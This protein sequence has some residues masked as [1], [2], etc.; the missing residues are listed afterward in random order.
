MRCGMCEAGQV[1][2]KH[3]LDAGGQLRHSAMCLLAAG[4][5]D[6]RRVA[7]DAASAGRWRDLFDLC[8]T[9]KVLS[10]LEMRIVALGIVLR[11]A[12]RAELSRSTQPAFVQS[13]LCLRAGATALSVLHQAGIE[14][15]GFK[16]I[17]AL[18]YVYAGPRHRTLQDVDV[19]IHRRDVELS[20]EVLQRAGF[21][22]SPDVPWNEYVAFLR[23]SPG[24]AG[25][26][27]VSLR[28][29]RGGAVDLH[30]HLGALE[31]ETLLAGASM[32]DVLQR[33]LPLMSASHSMLLSVHHA[34]RNDFVP[35]DI[36]RDVCDFPHWQAL[37]AKRGEWDKLSEDAERWGLS[38]ACAALA[39]IVAGLRGEPDSEPPLPVSPEDQAA[40]KQLA[41]FYFHQL[42]TGAINTDLAYVASTRPARQVL[43]GLTCG[44][45][46]YRNLM[47]QSE[48]VNG[49]E[50]LSVPHRLWRLGKSVAGLSSAEWKQV[51]AL[52][53]AKG[54]VADQQLPSVSNET[55]PK[56]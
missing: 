23:N 1:T 7:E 52:A 13:M 19:L 3:K 8:E 31:V 45:K 14:C 49:E 48:Q 20:L 32:V 11:P 39:G 47:R 56:E 55:G 6:S 2:T 26:E 5:M 46:E 9:W 41:A 27:A 25:N 10:A 33:P 34:L 4:D 38:A 21:T 44:W 54:K 24:T 16:G 30:W 35:G 50:S 43:A 53:R 22:R 18:A 37:L 15:A 12:E 17:A 29:E 36:A 40:A 28:D 51:R 42:F